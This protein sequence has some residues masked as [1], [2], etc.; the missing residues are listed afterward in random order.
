MNKENKNRLARNDISRKH[1]S[2]AMFCALYC[3]HHD[4]Q[5]VFIKKELFLSLLELERLKGS[6]FDWIREDMKAYFPY[7]FETENGVFVLSKIE[8]GELLKNEESKS[9]AILL[10]PAIFKLAKNYST[11][12]SLLDLGFDENPSLNPNDILENNFPYLN[13]AINLY[14]F[15]IINTL[16]LMSN[17]L[18]EPELALKKAE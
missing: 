5:A 16:S 11:E 6:R 12:P 1:R 18:I 14:E 13:S 10:N 4:K 15:S 2:L 3:W 9:M 17:G 7:I 8:K